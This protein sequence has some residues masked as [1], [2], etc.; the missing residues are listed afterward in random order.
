MSTTHPFETQSSTAQERETSHADEISLADLWNMLARRRWLI[1][2][3]WALVLLTAGAY[4]LMTPPVFESRSVIQVGRF[5]GTTVT[6]AAALGLQL[7]ERYRVGEPGRALPF[8]SDIK[9][10]GDDIVMLKAV[11]GSPVEAQ[12]LLA[13]V[14]EELL[15]EQRK[16]YE[17]AQGVRVRALQD[18]ETQLASLNEQMARLAEVAGTARTDEAV[19]ALVVLQRS[20]LQA[21][22]PEL[23]KQRLELQQELSGLRSYPTQLVRDPTLA[24]GASS[25]RPIRVMAIAVVLGLAL[26]VAVAFFAAFLHAARARRLAG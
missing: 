2:A 24:L 1:A 4:L 5:A 20:S 17:A 6:P 23:H 16:H 19:R 18:V 15:G 14:A 22:L 9:T 11:G 21:T 7:Q 8:I 13:G 3:V 12:D 26:G 10:L 25:P